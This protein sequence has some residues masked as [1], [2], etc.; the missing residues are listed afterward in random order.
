M[1]AFGSFD[2]ELLLDDLDGSFWSQFMVWS[3]DV[4][5]GHDGLWPREHLH[6][7][8]DTCLIPW[9]C[10]SNIASARFWRLE[11]FVM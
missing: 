1:R 7:S 5:D 9:G 4:G 11:G 6:V 3:R 10:F 8:S 2:F